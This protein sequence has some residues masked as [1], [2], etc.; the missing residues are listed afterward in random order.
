[1]TGERTRRKE[2]QRIAAARRKRVLELTI[3]GVP[4]REIAELVGVRKSQVS[5]DYAKALAET[6][7]PEEIGRLRTLE[8]LRL[9]YLWRPLLEAFN[10]SV[11]AGSPD[12]ALFDRLVKISARRA[13][14]NGL[15]LPKEVAVQLSKPPLPEIIAL[16]Y[17][18]TSEPPLGPELE[19]Q[20]DSAD[21]AE[22][23][24]K[25]PN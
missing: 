15:D 4:Q 13:A 20:S 21:E 9:D 25:L 18:P 6:V 10:R 23:E 16:T 12:L 17:V 5:R 7:S 24:G 1:M 2:Q 19:R 11:E 3:Q 14:L 8:N 22:S